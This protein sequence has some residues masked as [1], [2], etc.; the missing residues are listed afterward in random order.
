MPSVSPV[1]SASRRKIVMGCRG[2]GRIAG[3]VLG[4]VATQVVHLADVPVTL[5]K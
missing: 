5:V 1:L 4:S 2:L 3:L